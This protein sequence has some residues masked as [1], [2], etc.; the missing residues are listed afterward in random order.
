MTKGTIRSSLLHKSGARGPSLMYTE[1]TAT[2][3]EP[4]ADGGG[5]T[6]LHIQWHVHS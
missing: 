4:D 2:V 5:Y 6:Y 3:V 1:D